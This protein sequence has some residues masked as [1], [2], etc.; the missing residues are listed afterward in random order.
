MDA[1]TDAL[2]PSGTATG[3]PA[4]EGSLSDL[5]PS[6]LLALLGQTRQTGTLQILAHGPVLLTL[7]DGAVSYATDDPNRTL[8]D[9][10]REDG[11]LD[12]ATW[13]RAT[14]AEGDE[15]ELGEALVRAGVEP[16]EVTRAVRR[17]VLDAVVDLSLLHHGRFR[18][19]PGRRHSLGER[20]HY[21]A[22]EVAADLAARLAEWE[23]IRDLVPAFDLRG[24]LR[25]SLAA[26]AAAVTITPSQWRVL[27]ALCASKDLD[28]A[29]TS[30][31]SSRFALA[32]D[33][34]ALVR[35]GAL[36]LVPTGDA[37]DTGDTE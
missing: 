2:A 18:F 8:R 22:R 12:D 37:G 32:T 27:V 23:A 25:P 15:Q 7:V 34:A 17:A 16:D 4:L 24:R 10:L 3:R 19:V 20:F 21:P 14:A 26:G 33:V 1:V 5:R 31:G 11:V 13:D 36:E 9:I 28:A 30:L 29:R 6:E 35:A